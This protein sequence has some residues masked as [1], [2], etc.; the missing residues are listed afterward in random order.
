MKTGTSVLLLLALFANCSFMPNKK[1]TLLCLGDSYTIG[2]AVDENDRFP[3]Q[4]VNLLRQHGIELEQP[5]LVAKTGWT[6][7][8]LATAIK[9]AELK[10]SYHFVTL[11]I[12][13]NNQYRGRDIENYRLE[14][15]ELLNTAL[16]YANHL[17]RHVFVI[18]IPDWGP[19]PFGRND[20]RGVEKISEEIDL[21]N[22]VNQQETL[23]VNAHYIEITAQSREAAHDAELL[24]KDGLHPSGK[25]YALWAKKLAALIE[26]QISR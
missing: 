21:F 18:S 9:A 16:G 13:V 26:K 14:F 12:G 5:V 24:A 11:L 15:R 25:M 20:K 2:E 17:P 22:E 23:K 19:S 7:D 8:E 3:V 10:R 6:T 1:M 4:T